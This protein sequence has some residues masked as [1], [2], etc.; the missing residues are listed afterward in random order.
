MLKDY[1]PIQQI[2]AE[3]NLIDKL[4]LALIFCFP[5]FSLTL[6]HWLSGI[7]GLLILLA[8]IV[9]FRKHTRLYP[10]EKILLV[11]T[12]LLVLSFFLSATL[13]DWSVNSIRRIG[14]VAKYIF[15]A[16]FYLLLRRYL[17]APRLLLSGILI[18]SIILGLQSL[19]DIAFRPY[20]QGWGIY[21]PIIFGDLSVL[22]FGILLMILFIE[23][24]YLARPR[25]LG[26]AM[27]F[28]IVAGILS[29]SRNAW[30]AAS[31]SI[32]AVPLLS[33]KYIN[34][35][36]VGSVL[37]AFIIISIAIVT[38]YKPLNDRMLLGYNQFKVFMTEGAPRDLP[39]YGN[40]VGTRLEQWRSALHIYKEAPLFGFGGGNAAKEVNRFVKE[41]KAHPDLYNP[42]SE[43]NIGGLHSTY[44]ETLLNEGL[45]GLAIA[46]AFL[47]YPLYIFLRSRQ[48][49]PLLA[50]IGVIF[51]CNYLIFGFTENPLVHDNYTSVYL[52]FLAILFA[53]VVRQRQKPTESAPH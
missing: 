39:L 50:G 26:V 29:G 48:R 7:Y 20:H 34:F 33:A 40:S 25:A 31:F 51:S 47:L 30:L 46:L 37:L 10:E 1:L 23:R 5:L 28:A 19:Y 42:D 41:G 32:I 44:F 15:F 12:L 16:P 9:L 8:L 13:N 38:F 53:Q 45:V 22:F 43:T 11:L 35:R 4:V 24:Q 14:N 27:L 18:G 52:T 36:Q 17:A 2:R 21:G 3:S 6:R 49:D